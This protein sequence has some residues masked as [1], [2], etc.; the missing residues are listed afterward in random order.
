MTKKEIS[1]TNVNGE[2]N[3]NVLT[4]AECLG[5]QVMCVFKSS[6]AAFPVPISQSILLFRGRPHTDIPEQSQHI[7]M[8]HIC[9]YSFKFTVDERLLGREVSSKQPA[10]L[11]CNKSSCSSLGTYIHTLPSQHAES[12]NH[13]LKSNL[14]CFFSSVES[15]TDSK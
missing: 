6:W 14:L 12:T 5:Y 2:G 4:S 3:Y 15:I 13:L 7:L 9:S 1:R 10:L 11:I 8:I